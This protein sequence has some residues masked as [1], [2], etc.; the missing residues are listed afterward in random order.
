MCIDASIRRSKIA[1][2]CNVPTSNVLSIHDLSNVYHV[3]LLMIEQ[4]YD[5][6]LRNRLQLDSSTAGAGA[7]NL[8]AGFGGELAPSMATAVSQHAQAK[9]P[10]ATAATETE[11]E[12]EGAVTLQD[13]LV[14]D[15][16]A[17][18][19][20]VD[21]SVEVGQHAIYHL[22]LFDYLNRCAYA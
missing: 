12:A 8:D 5:T 20:R 3:P 15:W 1:L 17:L 22:C 7:S 9:P 4:G 14:E 18:A 6:L 13:T 11:T 21:H 16:R 10:A 19:D 2:F